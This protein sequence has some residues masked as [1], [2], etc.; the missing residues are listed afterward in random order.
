M[1]RM[2]KR[3]SRQFSGLA[4]IR[5]GFYGDWVRIGRAVKV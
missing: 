5:F 4:L 2:K 1:V 3:G